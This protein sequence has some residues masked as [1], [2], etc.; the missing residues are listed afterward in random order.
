MRNLP[1]LRLLA[2]N[3]TFTWVIREP[4]GR[5][6]RSGHRLLR[7]RRRE[8]GALALTTRLPRRAPAPLA[9]V[10]RRGV[11]RKTTAGGL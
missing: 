4:S 5:P 9:A 2:P 10:A 3:L 6:R 8:H 1:L 7:R 11:A